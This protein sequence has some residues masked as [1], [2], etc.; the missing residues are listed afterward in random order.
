MSWHWTGPGRGAF[1]G[2]GGLTMR[3]TMAC[4]PALRAALSA[5]VGAPLPPRALMMLSSRAATNRGP[6]TISVPRIVAVNP[7]LARASAAALAAAAIS[8]GASPCDSRA[9]R[10]ARIAGLL[11]TCACSGWARG[12]WITSIRNRS[13][14]GSLSGVRS[15]H[16]A[17][18]LGER[19][20]AEPQGTRSLGGG[21]PPGTQPDAP[22]GAG[23]RGR[24]IE[25][26]GGGAG[27]D[28]RADREHDELRS[29]WGLRCGG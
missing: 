2:V 6:T 15:E 18:S 26:R 21:H 5:P 14:F 11:T 28:D 20:G 23:R 29:H 27:G 4:R 7:P 16:P 19:T 12:T 13:L 8:S 24:H 1:P 3:S 10:S 22:I 17:S 9:A 25:L